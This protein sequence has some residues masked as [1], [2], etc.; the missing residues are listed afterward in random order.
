MTVGV[1]F[2]AR[3]YES[4]AEAV[5]HTPVV[6]LNRVTAGV[7][8]AVYVKLEY[9]NPGGS[10]KDRAALGMLRA[11]EAAGEL[12]PGGTVVE[13]TSGNTGLGLA[14]LA[15]ARGYRTIV[16]VPD[17][18]SQEKKAVLRAYGAEVRETPGLR[19]VGHPEHLR[20]VALRLVEEIPGAWFAGQY[21]NPANTAAHRATTG[22]EIWAQTGGRVTHFVAGV[23]TGGTITGAGE[24]LK[25]ASGGAVR[26]IGADPETS[27]YGG[28]DG[29]I[30]Y[31]EAVG[32]FRHPETAE[33]L[34]PEAYH[35][36]VVDRIERIPDVEAIGL[37]HRLAREEGLLL[38]GS[39]GT[40]IAAALRVARE[41]G[42]DD[43]VV[44][45]APDS[46]RAYLSKYYNDEWLGTLGFPLATPATDRTVGEVFSYLDRS[47]EAAA[48]GSAATVAEARQLLGDDGILPIMLQRNTSGPAVVSEIIGSVAASDLA[49]ATDTAPV[50]AYADEPLPLA[51]L[52][53][54]ARGAVAR[55]VEHH[56]PIV[57]VHEGRA[58]AIVD[59]AALRAAVRG[60]S[61]SA[62]A[63]EVST[64]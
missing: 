16:V 35:P 63:V 15:A 39:S 64:G 18:V 34:W 4:F 24:F 56:G 38:G 52:T 51:G 49:G 44:V 14:A 45:I 50:T 10:V 43:V 2:G 33:D 9:L 62:R 61:E 40:A 42:P 27:V 55:L 47:A 36:E 25:E 59:A 53:E 30:W 54:S 29:R 12:R 20:S 46:G 7:S 23:G 22:P 28:G 13:A 11:A 8:A 37:L 48:V 26:V 41:L 21:D 32:H 31:V 58:I 1:E 3:A 6:R 57:I 17:R 5:G 60:D 19:P